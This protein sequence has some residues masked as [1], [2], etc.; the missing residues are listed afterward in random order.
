MLV[1]KSLSQLLEYFA[2]DFIDQIFQN[3][4]MLV[5]PNNKKWNQQIILDPSFKKQ[6]QN[7]LP[8]FKNEQS[9][10]VIITNLLYYIFAYFA[11]QYNDKIYQM[12]ST[13]WNLEKII[14]KLHRKIDQNHDLQT[15]IVLASITSNQAII[16]D[17]YHQIDQQINADQNL[18]KTKETELVNRTKQIVSF[19]NKLYQKWLNWNWSTVVVN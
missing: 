17:K 13:N 16:W 11:N 1:I 8:I 2:D 15:T 14:K 19:K 4:N 10:K 9:D 6:V 12:L 5:N 3:Q 18:I 7:Q